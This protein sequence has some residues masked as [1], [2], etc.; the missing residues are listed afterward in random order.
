MQNYVH[1]NQNMHR[2]QTVDCVYICVFDKPRKAGLP[3]ALCTDAND[4][5]PQL[6]Q[7]LLGFC[8]CRSEHGVTESQRDLLIS[9]HDRI[10]LCDSCAT[11]N[12]S[13]WLCVIKVRL[14]LV[15]PE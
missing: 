7:L 14:H 3:Q 12:I 13:F 1:N 8:G 9:T 11:S 6:F 2:N 5:S 15:A 4:I 10:M